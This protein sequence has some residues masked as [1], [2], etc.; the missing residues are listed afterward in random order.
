VAAEPGQHGDFNLRLDYKLKA[1]GNSG[2]IRVPGSDHHGDGTEVQ[3]QM[4]RRAL[5]R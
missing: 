1:G 4:M 3:C 2:D 5:S